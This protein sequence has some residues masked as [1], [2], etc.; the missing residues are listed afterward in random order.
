MFKAYPFFIAAQ[1][2]R[3]SSKPGIVTQIL[4]AM[5]GWPRAA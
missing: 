1:D 3:R 2:E 4:S 5:F